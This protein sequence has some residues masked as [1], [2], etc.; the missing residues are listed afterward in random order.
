MQKIIELPQKR[1]CV[2]VSVI[3]HPGG[4]V[5]LMNWRR[6][7]SGCHKLSVRIPGGPG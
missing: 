7:A 3:R 2:C 6:E 4:R 1:V 5:I